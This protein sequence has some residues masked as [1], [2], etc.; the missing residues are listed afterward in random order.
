MEFFGES[1]RVPKYISSYNTRAQKQFLLSTQTKNDKW[2]I[3][4]RLWTP[5]PIVVFSE[6]AYGDGEEWSERM[7]KK[8]RNAFSLEM[9]FQKLAAHKKKKRRMPMNGATAKNER[10]KLN[11]QWMV[12]WI[13]RRQQWQWLWWKIIASPW[14]IGNRKSGRGDVKNFQ[15]K[16]WWFLDA[17]WTESPKWCGWRRRGCEIKAHEMATKNHTKTRFLRFFFLYPAADDEFDRFES[18]RTG[19][20]DGRL[21]I[22]PEQKDIRGERKEK[23]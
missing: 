5:E 18:C 17:S 13:D 10:E 3:K 23:C 7:K 16:L 21:V 22:N 15:S 2:L 14:S 19:I 11:F 8:V 6:S 20:R 9:L 1:K 4:S 12:N